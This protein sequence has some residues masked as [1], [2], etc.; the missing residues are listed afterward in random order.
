MTAY[1]SHGNGVNGTE[2][3]NFAFVKQ[4][5]TIVPQVDLHEWTLKDG[6]IIQFSTKYISLVDF[7]EVKERQTFTLL[8][9]TNESMETFLFIIK[10]D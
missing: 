1:R 2:L 4:R 7:N 9:A 10:I 8:G 3:I 5:R 6:D